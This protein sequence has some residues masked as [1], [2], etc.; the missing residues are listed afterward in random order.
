MVY[1][2]KMVDLSMAMLNNQMVTWV[3][4]PKKV[5][6]SRSLTC[7][8]TPHQGLV[9]ASPGQRRNTQKGESDGN[10]VLYNRILLK[11]VKG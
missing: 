1:L 6:N 8:E 7:P 5:M 9:E 11:L 2:L 4:N 10:L 3:M